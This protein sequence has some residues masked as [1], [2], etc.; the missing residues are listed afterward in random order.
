M[1]YVHH[2]DYG[3]NWNGYNNNYNN[4]VVI[5]RNVNNDCDHYGN[6]FSYSQKRYMYNNYNGAQLYMNHSN[7]WGNNW[8]NSNNW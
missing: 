5:Y 3:Q 1:I 4:R 8:N 6:D 2:M 7:T